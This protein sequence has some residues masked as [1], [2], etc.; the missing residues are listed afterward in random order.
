MRVRGKDRHKKMMMVVEVEVE[1]GKEQQQEGRG[2]G[3]DEIIAGVIG[4][5]RS[6]WGFAFR[7]SIRLGYSDAPEMHQ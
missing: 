2:R 1:V 4:F 3:G 6:N 5:T 7:L